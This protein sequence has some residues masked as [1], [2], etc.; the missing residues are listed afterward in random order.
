ML[1]LCSASQFPCTARRFNAAAIL[2]N[3]VPLQFG[4][5]RFSSVAIPCASI[6]LPRFAFL[7]NSTAFRISTNP[8]P[9]QSLLNISP[10]VLVPSQLSSAFAFHRN[11]SPLRNCS[12]PCYSPAQP[13]H[14]IP[15]LIKSFQRNSFPIHGVSLHSFAAANLVSSLLFP[16]FTQFFSALPRH[17]IAIPLLDYAHQCLRYALTYSHVNA[18]LPLFLH[19]PMPLSDP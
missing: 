16:R 19:W 10:A 11:S 4:T 15:M 8:L 1:F 6:P 18:P 5:E 13:Y 9:F 7:F 14:A 17:V 3:S 2:C 12:S